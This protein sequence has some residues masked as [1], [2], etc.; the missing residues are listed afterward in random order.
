MLN[1]WLT[2]IKQTT[3]FFSSN[4]FAY[5]F[6]LNLQSFFYMAK[7]FITKALWFSLY[8]AISFLNDHFSYKCCNYLL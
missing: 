7:S 1:G 8:I 4:K 6:P 2:S 5:S 3:I